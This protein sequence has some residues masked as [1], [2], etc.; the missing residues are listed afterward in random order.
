MFPEK[1]ELTGKNK[2]L[3]L[4]INSIFDARDSATKYTDA[5]KLG[6]DRGYTVLNKKE[7]VFNPRHPEIEDI[8][9]EIKP[10][11]F[12]EKTLTLWFEA[13]GAPG[14]LFGPGQPRHLNPE[15]HPSHKSEK[16]ATEQF[17]HY[18]TDIEH[19]TQLKI[20]C[21][22]LNSCF[23]A[24]ELINDSTQQ[25]LNSNARL[26]SILIP[27][28]LVLGFMGY[29][30]SAKV[31]HI[32]EIKQSR[33]DKNALIITDSNLLAE[34]IIS[35]I[36][37]SIV[38]KDGNAIEYDDHALYCSKQNMQPYVLKSLDISADSNDFYKLGPAKEKVDWL[39]KHGIFAEQP[40][41]AD[42]QTENYKVTAASFNENQTRS[43]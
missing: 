41:F 31:S 43:Y 25:Y 32:W 16:Q 13:H 20:D 22:L 39:R 36:E 3:L 40:C 42:K 7:L 30:C 11:I 6:E 10:I 37:A 9:N 34:C 8:K 15:R 28:K 14:W 4:I 35:L 23:S 33:Q 29:N 24:S 1:R 26:L 38:F 21:I 27:D 12:P 5:K 2:P 18:L 19:K 17:Y